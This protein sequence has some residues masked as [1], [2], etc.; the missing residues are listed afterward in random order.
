MLVRS[1][2]RRALGL[3]F[4]VC[5]ATAPAAA[6]EPPLPETAAMPLQAHLERIVSRENEDWGILAW[7]L[8]REQ[9]L[10]AVNPNRVMIPASN[11]KVFTAVWALAVLGPDY[12]FRTELLRGGPIESGVLRGDVYLRGSGDPAFGYPAYDKD[13]MQPLRTMARQLRARGVRVVEGDVVGDASVFDTARFGPEWPRDTGNGAS[14]YAPTVSGL[15]FQRNL[16]WV[17]AVPAGRQVSIQLDPPITEIPVQSS[18]RLGGRRAWA[19]R[20]PG[21]DTIEVK[22]AVSGRGPF[23]FGVGVAVPELMTAAALRQALLQ[24]G[25]EVRGEAKLGPTPRDAVPVH[26]HYS[27]RLAE[28]IPRLNRDSDNF[29]AEHL[30]KAAAAK[31]TGKGSYPRGG[32]ASANFFIHRAGVPYGQVYQ[33]D[34][35]GLSAY[36]RASAYSLVR[37]LIYAHAQPWSEGFHHSLAVAASGDGTLRNLFRGSAAANNLHAKTGYIRGVRTLSG[38][39]TARNGETIVFSFLYNGRNTS[40]A[41][42]I[43]QQLGTLLADYGDPG[44]TPAARPQPPQPRAA[45]QRGGARARN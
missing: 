17:R 30:W 29:F 31:A 6:Q 19:V 24:E 21:S 39:V 15:P 32:P 20:Q 37:A 36:N 44:P 35:S 12:R 5:V 22:G 14:T 1:F 26:R 40:G 45:P 18:V 28:M 4:L 2:C 10:F 11:N 16:L 27:I 13:P 38:Y 43:Q 23:R 33:A 7:S 8:E 42:G 25:I 3:A 41:R 34:G 9:P